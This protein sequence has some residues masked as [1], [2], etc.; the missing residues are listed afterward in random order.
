MT[1]DL[2]PAKTFFAYM[3]AVMASGLTPNQRLI[4]IAQAKHAD[5]HGGELTNSY[6][7]EETLARETGLSKDTIQRTRKTLTELGWLVQTHSGRGGSSKLANS[8]D[9]AVPYDGGC[10]SDALAKPHDA[11]LQSRMMPGQSR[12][13]SRSKPHGAATSTC[14]STPRSAA[15]STAKQGGSNQPDQGT[16]EGHGDGDSY[17][18]GYSKKH[19]DGYFHRVEGSTRPKGNHVLVTLTGRQVMDLFGVPYDYDQRR[20]IM[21]GYARDAGLRPPARD[22]KVPAGSGTRY[23]E[24]GRSPREI[25]QPSRSGDDRARHRAE[26]AERARYFSRTPE[27]KKRAH[28]EY[29]R[30]MDALHR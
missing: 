1:D 30:Q 19:P 24:L 28:A 7:S 6:P 3:D 12:T 2:G 15:A 8:Y 18:V 29:R 10:Q 13:E 27:E 26:E 25:V 23:P 9:L 20:D 22:D 14:S 5:T 17:W 21:L 16:K 4:L 11:V